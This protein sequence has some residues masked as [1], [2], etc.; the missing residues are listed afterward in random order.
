MKTKQAIVCLLMMIMI[1]NTAVCA[2]EHELS[3]EEHAAHASADIIDTAGSYTPTESEV[4]L[5]NIFVDILGCSPIVP[6][7]ESLS[8]TLQLK[9]I[10]EPKTGTA[11]WYIDG[12]PLPE[13]YYSQFEFSEGKIYKLLYPVNFTR[14]TG[15]NALVWLDMVAGDSLRRI[16]INIPLQVYSEEFYDEIAK[17]Q[18]KEMVKTV[19]IDATVKYDTYLYS[20]KYLKNKTKLIKK[21]ENVKYK[22]SFEFSKTASSAYVIV[23]DG[24]SAY[25]NYN[26]ISIS[27]KNYTVFH[28]HSTETKENFVNVMGYVSKT[29]YLTWIN[30]ERQKVNVFIGSGMGG[31]WKLLKAFS[32]A[33]GANKTPTPEGVFEYQA[34]NYSWKFPT[35]YVAPVLY[36]DM[37]RGLAFHSRLYNYKN[38]LI[39]ATIGTPASH[40]C[41]RMYDD[42]VLWL[43]HYLPF[44]TAVYVH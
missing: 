44:T 17:A 30:I 13:Y 34:W 5:N 14:D 12:E 8:V 11:Q 40:G 21:G 1:Q 22:D 4:Y 39:D 18:A 19:N 2:D 6:Y 10:T 23:N 42:D 16:E 7:G 37:Y 35:Y 3:N 25:I 41:I 32:C 38:V 24:S 36:F 15:G 27:N 33:T 28:D 43:R 31:D 26:D 9:N 20:D 29:N